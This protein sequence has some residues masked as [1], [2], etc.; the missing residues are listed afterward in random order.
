MLAS[1]PILNINVLPRRWHTVIYQPDG[2][3]Q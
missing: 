3:L 2:G 1:L